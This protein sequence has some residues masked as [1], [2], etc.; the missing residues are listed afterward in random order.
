MRV[1]TRLPKKSP[2][3]ICPN[4]KCGKQ[5]EES[6]ILNVLS[7][8]PPKQY[9]ACPYCFTQLEKEKV[10]ESPKKSVQP[11]IKDVKE[12]GSGMFGRVRSL[13]PNRNKTEEIEEIRE[14]P[15]A[16]KAKSQ[17]KKFDKNEKKN[18]KSSSKDKQSGCPEYFGYLANRP[19][20]VSIPQA[21]LTCPKM[22]DCM[23]SPKQ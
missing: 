7:V 22:V 6:I 14:K 18:E 3:V 19:S 12:S 11:S 8:S 9:E 5:I 23:L 13:I 1:A 15:T 16:P 10:T 2:G 4:P 17:D 21:C 20:D